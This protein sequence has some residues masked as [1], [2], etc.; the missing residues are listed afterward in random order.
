MVLHFPYR[1]Q[2]KLPWF[3]AYFLQ[4]LTFRPCFKGGPMKFRIVFFDEDGSVLFFEEFWV[5][6]GY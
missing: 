2:S 3:R 4:P 5:Y 1:N 6:F